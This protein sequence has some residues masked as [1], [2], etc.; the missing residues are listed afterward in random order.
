MQDNVSLLWI[1]DLRQPADSYNKIVLLWFMCSRVTFRHYKIWLWFPR[2]N[3]AMDRI[4]WFCYGHGKIWLR[5]LLHVLIFKI[6]WLV[7]SL[8][9]SNI[10]NF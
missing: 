6:Q 4:Y 5:F 7:L 8:A 2:P 3:H 9:H 1:Y 10:T